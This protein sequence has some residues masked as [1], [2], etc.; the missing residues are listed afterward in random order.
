MSFDQKWERIDRLAE[1]A[2]FPHDNRRKWRERGGVPYHWHHVI[3]D[4]AEE[5][6]VKLQR[7]DLRS[8]WLELQEA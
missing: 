3:L 5:Q 8:D 6:K 7:K 2:G 4:Q 1:L